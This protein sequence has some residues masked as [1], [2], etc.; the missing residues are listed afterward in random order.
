[1]SLMWQGELTTID[2]MGSGAAMALFE[3]FSPRR[4]ESSIVPRRLR[5]YTL[6]S[7][8]PVDITEAVSWNRGHCPVLISIFKKN[9]STGVLSAIQQ[10]NTKALIEVENYKNKLIVY[11][12][13]K[14]KLFGCF[15]FLCDFS[16]RAK[17]HQ[18]YLFPLNALSKL[19]M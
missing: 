18:V 7:K 8:E 13:G 1:M 5:A 15:F 19:I 9:S 3:M 12:S 14:K 17:D 16:C 4:Q 10:Q 6:A 2:C 11:F